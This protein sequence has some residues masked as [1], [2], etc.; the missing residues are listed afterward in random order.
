MKLQQRPVAEPVVESDAEQTPEVPCYDSCVD[1]LERGSDPVPV[2]DSEFE[3]E[4][5]TII[6]IMGGSVRKGSWEPPEV[7]RVLALMGGAEL[8]FSEAIM[9]E[10]ISEVKI[11]AL[12]GGVAIKVPP[13][14]N[15]QVRGMGIM[16]GFTE[17]SQRV[18]DPEAPT[19]RVQGYA[20]MGGVEVKVKK[21]KKKWFG[22]K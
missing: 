13:D 17:L 11:F 5:E 9:L 16:G 7:L 19:L 20:I 8:D 22:K 4:R 15:V 2:D 3:A 18:D 10:G 12:M 14:I 1:D 21:D 6:A